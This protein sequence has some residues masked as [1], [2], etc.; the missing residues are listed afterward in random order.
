MIELAAIILIL[1]FFVFPV[2][3]S[4]GC[5]GLYT[6]WLISKKYESFKNQPLE[7]KKI[8]VIWLGTFLINLFASLILGVL[9]AFLI[10]YLIFDNFYLFLFNFIFC[11]LISIRWFDFSYKIYQNLIMG[12]KHFEE[13][14]K[15]ETFFVICQG[16]KQRSNWGFGWTPE[17]TDAGFLNIES[18]QAEFEGIFRR[19]TFNS[20]DFSNMERKSSDKI[21]IF[22]HD[23]GIHQS[24]IFL[25]TLKEQ[26]YPFRSRASRDRIF[27]NF[28]FGLKIPETP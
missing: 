3:T 4:A 17:F 13:K 1:T 20:K 27:S 16:F 5:L 22:T 21:Q 11:F 9:L 25:I 28:S 18:N 26:F 6:T 19:E 14:T 8:L 2:H 12:L 7:G 24:H 23:A 10:Y 15:G